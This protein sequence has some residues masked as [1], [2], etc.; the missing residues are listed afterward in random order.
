MYCLPVDDVC[1]LSEIQDKIVMEA[2]I[3]TEEPIYAEIDGWT[4]FIIDDGKLVIV[5]NKD[6]DTSGTKGN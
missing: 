4:M 5:R 1:H 3:D 2:R 6:A